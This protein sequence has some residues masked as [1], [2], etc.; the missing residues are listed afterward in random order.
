MTEFG[1]SLALLLSAASQASVHMI[2]KAAGDK[3]VI[4]SII[5]LIEAVI[6][7]PLIVFVP[8]PSGV[9]WGW[10][11]L[12]VV[13]HLIYQL[14]LI[15]AYKSLD[16]SV[17]YPLA[18]G[19]APIATAMLGA[20]FLGDHLGPLAITGIVAVSAGLITVSLGA[21]PHRNVL[22]AAII[23]GLLTTAYS[24]IDAQGIRSAS[25]AFT[26]IVWFFA[27]D[28]LVILS[29]TV[30]RRGRLLPELMKAEGY[31][32]LIGGGIS[33]F[34]YT[35]ALGAFRLISIG[36]ATALRETSVVF[37]SL[38]ARFFLKETIPL[39]RYAGI[40]LIIVGSTV[41]AFNL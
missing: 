7:I 8:W 37:A 38:L 14:V 2:W 16:F 26:F 9:V 4:R 30:F 35:A 3:L 6:M 27:I 12:S 23:A 13:V 34:G 29:I 24:V 32:G 11:F 5:G 22:I 1:V 40:F 39:K 33:L 20:V 41:L 15:E 25:N 21:K 19:V 28:G 17:A 18:R 10:L 31:R 36:A